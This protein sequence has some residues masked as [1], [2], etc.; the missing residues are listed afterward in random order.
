MLSPW[1]ST[2]WITAHTYS[3]SSFS[4]TQL[5]VDNTQICRCGHCGTCEGT[6]ANHTLATDCS[7]AARSLPGNQIGDAGATE[8]AKALAANSTLMNANFVA[9]WRKNWCDVS[10]DEGNA[11]Q[12]TR[13]GAHIPSYPQSPSGS[14]MGYKA[15]KPAAGKRL[16][17]K[18]IHRLQC[19]PPKHA[20]S[21]NMVV[22]CMRRT[23]EPPPNKQGYHP[24]ASGSQIDFLTVE[25]RLPLYGGF[26][27]ENCLAGPPFSTDGKLPLTT[28]FRLPRRL[29]DP[30][31]D[32]AH[33][34]TP[35][36]P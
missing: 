23:A 17:P 19:R 28:L 7:G 15:S 22:Q 13:K 36:A 33:L 32:P 18:H 14:S 16:T 6:G 34:V 12:S 2:T 31:W 26:F 30:V 11:P 5:S 4:W 21:S 8:A 35:S 29:D 27:G 1:Y 9:R 20:L 24:V 25:A 10:G 3:V